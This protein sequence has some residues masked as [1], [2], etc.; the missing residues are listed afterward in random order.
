VMLMK[1]MVADLRPGDRV[2]SYFSVKF[3]KA[4][5]EYKYGWMF[6]I[7]LSDA[8]GEIAAK[9]WG[10]PG[11]AEVQAVFDSFSSGDVVR[12]A[13]EAREFGP[14]IELGI[15]PKSGGSVLRLA[16]GEYD[17]DDLIAKSPVDKEAMRGELRALC[18]TVKNPHLASVLAAFFGDGGAMDAFSAAPASMQMH[19]NYSGG[20]LEHSVKVA[21]ICDAMAGLYPGVD[22][23][24]LVAG[25][26]LHDVGKVRELEMGTS[27]EVSDEGMFVGH[28]V[29]G[30]AMVAEAVA[31][32]PDFPREMGLKLAHMMLSHHGHKEWG[33]PKE[34]QTAEALL[35]HL[36][37]MAD[38]QVFQFLR[39]RAEARTDD[40]W[41]WD[42]RLGHI[43]LK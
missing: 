33:S 12:V 40:D 15:N 22:R 9:Y 35:L 30:E 24:L 42:R 21:R 6:E 14:G 8:S 36:A 38:S 4:P 7:R 13:G 17:L 1:A 28:V 5:R 19:S 39:A 11:Q 41:T 16:E 31:S 37:D 2:A 3:K 25:A 20:L 29:I 32:I 23:D 18:A 26:L 10:P 43:Y 34:P 27:I